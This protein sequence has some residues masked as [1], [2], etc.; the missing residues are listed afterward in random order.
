MERYRV[1]VYKKGIVVIPKEVRE[2]LGIKEGDVLE[3]V[4]EGDRASIEKPETL[5]DLFG[6]DGEDAVEIAK[7]VTKE[8]RK[9][10]EREVRD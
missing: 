5:L 1:K 2:K 7:E 4:I 10:V 3:L 9:E 8:R 6:V